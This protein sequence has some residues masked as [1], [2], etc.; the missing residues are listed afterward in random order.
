MFLTNGSDLPRSCLQDKTCALNALCLK[1]AYTAQLSLLVVW[2]I[3]FS[4]RSNVLEP[5]VRHGVRRVRN[6]FMHSRKLMLQGGA[7][8]LTMYVAHHAKFDVIIMGKSQLMC[9]ITL[10]DLFLCCT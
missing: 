10:S 4:I 6:A 7:S 3:E 8:K 2:L 9:I 1:C 5:Q